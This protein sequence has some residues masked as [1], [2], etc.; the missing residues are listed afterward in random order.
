MYMRSINLSQDGR[1]IVRARVY[2]CLALNRKVCILTVYIRI[3]VYV[4][5]L[6]YTAVRSYQ[7]VRVGRNVCKFVFLYTFIRI[8]VYAKI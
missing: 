8:K 7:Y 6:E 3:K 1:I 5:Q 2:I 4:K